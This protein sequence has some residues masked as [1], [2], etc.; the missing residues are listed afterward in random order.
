MEQK[1]KS[2]PH[3]GFLSGL[4]AGKFF[5]NKQKAEEGVVRRLGRA[6]YFFAAMPEEVA[7]MNLEAGP[8]SQIRLADGRIVPAPVSEKEIPNIYEPEFLALIAG[9]VLASPHHEQ[10]E[11][12]RQTDEVT[13]YR[14]PSKVTDSLAELTPDRSDLTLATV[15]AIADQLMKRQDVS[16]KFKHGGVLTAAL[17]LRGHALE[18]LPRNS[19][20]EVFYWFWRAKK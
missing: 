18:A 7:A 5:G 10:L 12:V 15:N 20:K 13:L 17:I 6:G 8:K 3:S 9:V 16:S 1:P 2:N 11:V 14:F 4:K 19:G